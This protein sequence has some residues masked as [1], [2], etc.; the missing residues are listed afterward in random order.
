MYNVTCINQ[1]QP[2]SKL[3]ICHGKAMYYAYKTF[4]SHNTVLLVAFQDIYI[5]Q[6]SHHY[7]MGTISRKRIIP[8]MIDCKTHLL[9]HTT[10][11]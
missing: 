6:S 9:F 5:G 2:I 1:E 3:L 4:T 11:S 10:C 7:K 8:V